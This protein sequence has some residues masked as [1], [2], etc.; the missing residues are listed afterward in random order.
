MSIRV[1]INGFGR[2]GRCFLRA[3]WGD[4][5]LEIVAVN[6]P[7]ST[8]HLRYALQYD[9]VHGTFPHLVSATS[10]ALVIDG[11]SIQVSHELTP[12]QCKWNEIGV[13]VVVEASGRFITKSLAQ[14]HLN[15]GAAKVLVTAS[16]DLDIPM[17][18]MGVNHQ[19]YD[20]EQIFSNASCTTNC[21]AVITHVLNQHFG[22]E[23]GLI[24]T[25]HATT[26]SQKVVDAPSKKSLRDGRSALNNIIPSSTGATTSLGRIIP[27][28]ENK[29]RGISYRVPVN[30]VCVAD[31]NCRLA[32][33][34]SFK[35][36][37]T[38]F[39]DLSNSELSNYL[40]FTEDQLTSSDLSGNPHS[41]IFDSL[42]STSVNDQF[43]KIVSWYDNEWGYANRL[44]DL[45]THTTS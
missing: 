42:A 10:E 41:A 2:I 13:D 3:A 34:V 14:G 1:G 35:N 8:E 30:S 36:L 24:A 11:Q 4:S 26:S 39:R 19:S 29:L 25:I 43:V 37:T 7:N 20:N 28:L 27:E 5:N 31:I 17:F 33:P 9:S 6:D 21:V 23:D 32:S 40:G 18:V 44:R 45:I 12:E 16:T 38:L 15:A 22:V